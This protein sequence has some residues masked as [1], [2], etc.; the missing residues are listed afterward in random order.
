MTSPREETVPEFRARARAWLAENMPPVP[1]DTDVRQRAERR[2]H[3]RALQ[4]T[5][6]DGG[7]AGIAALGN[8]WRR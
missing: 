8:W 4:R 6:Y 7:F 3:E 5:L 2:V 1:D